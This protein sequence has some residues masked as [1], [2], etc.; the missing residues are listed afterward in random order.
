[1]DGIG[2]TH[3]T[4]HPVGGIDGDDNR[5]LLRILI[6]IQALPICICPTKPLERLGGS[7]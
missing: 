4:P 3:N 5:A 2:N 1:M 6:D 7:S